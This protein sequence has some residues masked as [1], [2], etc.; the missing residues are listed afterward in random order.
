MCVCPSCASWVV[1]SVTDEIAL[2]E[3]GNDDD[4]LDAETKAAIFAGKARLDALATRPRAVAARLSAAYDGDGPGLTAVEIEVCQ[5][6]L[7]TLCTCAFCTWAMLNLFCFLVVNRQPFE[8]L[9]PVTRTYLARASRF[10]PVCSMERTGGR[11]MPV[12]NPAT[13]ATMVCS[14]VP[15]VYLL[16]VAL[17]HS[18]LN[19]LA[20]QYT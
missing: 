18:T 8:T 11:S 9:L 10:N 4:K 17:P 3:Y 7:C 15:F 1:S 16:F 19:Q 2:K 5:S 12:G 6:S 14:C 13:T 20:L